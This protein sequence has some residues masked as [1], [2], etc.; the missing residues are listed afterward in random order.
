VDGDSFAPGQTVLNISLRD[1]GPGL[2]AASH[3]VLDDV[4]HCLNAGTSPDLAVR[5]FGHRGFI[6]GTLAQ[7]LLGEV[8]LGRDKPRIFSPFGLGVLDL[9]VGYEIF[10]TA[11]AAGLSLPAP[12]FFAEVERW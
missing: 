9:A 8:T 3:N 1:I 5:E 10:R 11:L 7:L 4:E 2:I 12:G 6:D